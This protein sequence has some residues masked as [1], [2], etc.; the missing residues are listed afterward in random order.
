MKIFDENGHKL[1][2]VQ[3]EGCSGSHTTG[4]WAGACGQHVA[5]AGLSRRS[6]A[7]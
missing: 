1:Q 7:A 6:S 2:V 3:P 4:A 5:L